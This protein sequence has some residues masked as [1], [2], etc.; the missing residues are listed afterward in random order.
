MVRFIV[1]AML[2]TRRSL[3]DLDND[4]TVPYWTAALEVKDYFEAVS[5]LDM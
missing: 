3:R 5:K 2:E 4:R 1:L